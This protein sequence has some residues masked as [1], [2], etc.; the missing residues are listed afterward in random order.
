MSSTAQC[1]GPISRVIWHGK[2]AHSHHKEVSHERLK[3]DHAGGDGGAKDHDQEVE[4]AEEAQQ[5][6][7][8]GQLAGAARN[9]WNTQTGVSIANIDI[10]RQAG[11]SPEHDGHESE[12][13]RPVDVGEQRGLP[14]VDPLLHLGND[15]VN[16]DVVV[17]LLLDDRLPL[18]FVRV[19]VFLR[20]R[21]QPR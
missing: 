5:V 9:R 1:R 18:T 7:L 3:G 11:A 2:L 16:G 8:V 4:Q 19:M 20:T 17:V 13:E 6:L 21:R 10:S 14:V 15:A 12:D